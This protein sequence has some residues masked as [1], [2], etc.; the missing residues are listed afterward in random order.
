MRIISANPYLRCNCRIMKAIDDI[1][2][3]SQTFGLKLC[4][5]SLLLLEFVFS[6][7]WQLLDASLDDEG[8]LE[9]A[10]EKNFRW[11]T[12]PEDMNID[13]LDSFNEK[14]TEHH[15][16]LCK[17]NTMMAIEIIGEFL[18]NKVTSRILYLSRRNM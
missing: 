17:V 12:R 1:L 13:S 2:H 7:V 9:L 10:P 3:L 8:L 5:P 11:P 6:V 18:K 16:G 14:R 4:E 15:E